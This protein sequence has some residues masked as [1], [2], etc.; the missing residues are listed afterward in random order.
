MRTALLAWMAKRPPMTISQ[1][2]EAGV[3]DELNI[4]ARENLSNCLHEACKC[5]DSQ[6]NTAKIPET[7]LYLGSFPRRS[8]VNVYRVRGVHHD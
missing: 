2:I 7:H 1:M 4:S 6:L 3:L 8:W 5:K